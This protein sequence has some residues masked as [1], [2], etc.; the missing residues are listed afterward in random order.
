MFILLRYGCCLCAW[1]PG[2]AQGGAVVIFAKIVR[3]FWNRIKDT[4]ML[5]KKIYYVNFINGILINFDW[6]YLKKY[7]S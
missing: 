3:L 2:P 6:K 5:Y 1:Q 4:S 7:A